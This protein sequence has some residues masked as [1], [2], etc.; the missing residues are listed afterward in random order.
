MQELI[1]NIVK[2]NSELTK[3]GKVADYI[4]ALS[5]VN[6]DYLGVAVKDSKGNLYYSGDY[7]KKFTLQSI[8]KT[9]SLMLAL[10]DNGEEKVFEKVGME[11]TGDAFNSIIKL[12]TMVPSK[13]LN[14]MINAGAIAIAS[15]IKGKNSEEK[16]GRLLSLFRKISRNDKLDINEEVYLSEKRTGDR[17]RAMAYFMK[18]VGII[19]EDVE[20]VLDVYFKQCSI[21]VDCVDIA[22]IGL[23]LANRGI[24]PDTGEQITSEH[25]ART[26]KTFMVTCGM[27]NASG[28]FAIKVGVPAKSGVGG[29]I[30]AVVP[31]K[32]GIG[33]F[34]PALDEKG[35]SVGGYG[36]LRDLSKE[37][38]L[39]I[40]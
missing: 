4:P 37:F 9:I 28:E 38:N 8:S 16:F 32:M 15:L 34:G 27:Y 3:K 35:N 40:F 6:P 29:G 14:P 36:I 11:P 13:P 12:E 20:E 7:N 18:D 33:V 23:F 22:N 10:M 26:V 1:D 39:S 2:K 30:M 21:E 17:N 5:K 31:H 25:I 19:E 24:I